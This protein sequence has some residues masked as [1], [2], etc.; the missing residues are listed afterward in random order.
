MTF[1]SNC[2]KSLDES[3]NVCPGCG[4]KVLKEASL[5]QY[6]PRATQPAPVMPSAYYQGGDSRTFGILALVF[7]LISLLVPV[8]FLL[9][10]MF[11]ILGLIKEDRKGMPITGL[12]L[13]LTALL[14]FGAVFYFAMRYYR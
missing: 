5:Q 4:R 14:I 3:W 7:G 13:G 12:I 10:I 1:C 6:L 11:A 9:P 8:I 2:G